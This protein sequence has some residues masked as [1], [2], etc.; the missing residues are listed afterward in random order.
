MIAARA[1]AS[2]RQ[3]ENLEAHG[4]RPEAKLLIVRGKHEAR[5][6]SSG[7]QSACEMDPVKRADGCR[8]GIT[9]P[10]E[11]GA[12]HGDEADRVQHLEH[13]G[14]AI[15]EQRIREASDAGAVERAEALDACELV[16]YGSLDLWPRSEGVS[17]AEDAAQNDRCIDVDVH[18][19]AASALPA[20]FQEEL[21]DIE[22]KI[23]RRIDAVAYLGEGPCRLDEFDPRR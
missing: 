21:D 3:A 13:R 18:E 16:G 1:T 7:Q 6:L 10:V 8:E 9:G 14:S 15:G 11:H 22:P 5:D 4:P 12:R 20:V 23:Q 17:L 2:G 19:A